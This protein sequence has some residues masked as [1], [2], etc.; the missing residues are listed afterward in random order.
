MATL[1]WRDMV[2]DVVGLGLSCLV[3]FEDGCFRGIGS[4]E[5]YS[6]SHA[7]ICIQLFIPLHL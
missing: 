4:V 7:I 6:E 5:Y 3:G 1:P 2:V